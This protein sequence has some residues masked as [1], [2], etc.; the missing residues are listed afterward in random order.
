M[1]DSSPRTIAMIPSRR[2]ILSFV[3]FTGILI[4]S[5]AGSAVRGQDKS[6]WP[7]IYQ[8]FRNSAP[9]IDFLKLVGPHHKEAAKPGPEGLRITLPAD[10]P[11][12]QP[13]IVTTN[14][15]VTGDFELTATY[16]WLSVAKPKKGYAPASPSR[17]SPTGLE[18]S[19]PRSAA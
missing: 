6:D 7:E 16:E 18:T 11:V 19:S 12:N 17:C 15:E 2:F 1:T 9:L 10:R 14:F 13:V 4:F 5:S 8:N 3:F